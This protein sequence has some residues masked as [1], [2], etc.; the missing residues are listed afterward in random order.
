MLHIL[1]DEKYIEKLF[2]TKKKSYKKDITHRKIFIQ[3]ILLEMQ[4]KKIN[5]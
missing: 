3:R 2:Q 5:R 4:Q 1:S